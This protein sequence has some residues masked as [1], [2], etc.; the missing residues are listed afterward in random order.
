MFIKFGQGIAEAN[1]SHLLHPPSS[2][3]I[4]NDGSDIAFE[5]HRRLGPA[6]A[7]ADDAP[8]SDADLSYLDPAPVDPDAGAPGLGRERRALFRRRVRHGAQTL[9][10]RALDVA[11]WR[12][13]CFVA[14]QSAAPSERA[15]CDTQPFAPCRRRRP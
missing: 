8:S 6:A 14:Q 4:S 1:A 7:L 5:S 13:R 15:A 12:C 2:N 11:R 10:A 9:R 3:V